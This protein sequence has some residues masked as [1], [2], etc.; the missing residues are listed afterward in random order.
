MVIVSL[1]IK[2][3]FKFVHVSQRPKY[4]V[5]EFPANL[6]QK[7]VKQNVTRMVKFY[8]NFPQVGMNGITYRF[9]VPLDPSL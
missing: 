2:S 9:F 8:L 7:K 5:L 3:E 4:D 6:S 1:T